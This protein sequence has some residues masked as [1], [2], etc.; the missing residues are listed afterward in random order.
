MVELKNAENDLGFTLISIEVSNNLAKTRTVVSEKG[1]NFPVLID[2][3]SYSREHLHVMG[4][5]TTFI[6]DEKGRIRCRLVGYVADL[7]GIIRGVL[8]RM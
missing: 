5:P 8:E 2:S 3:D 6:I 4:T 1:I 7:E